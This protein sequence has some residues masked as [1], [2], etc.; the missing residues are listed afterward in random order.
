MFRLAGQVILIFAIARAAFGQSAETIPSFEVADVHVT[1]QSASSPRTGGSIRNGRY[2]IKNLTILDLISL[3]YGADQAKIQGGP[4]WLASDRFDIVAKVP[5]GTNNSTAGLMLRTLLADRFKLAIHNEDKPLP[6]YAL[7]STG[8]RGPQLKEASGVGG[9]C[10]TPPQPNAP[11]EI[12]YIVLSCRNMLMGNIAGVIRAVAPGYLN[13]PVV[14][15]TD[16]KGLWDIELKWT[17]WDLLGA[18][19]SSAISLFDGIEKQ[20]GLKL[21]QRQHPMPVTVVDR[22]NQKPTDNIPDVVQKLPP[23]PPAEFEVADI[24]PS[25]PGA[26]QRGG[27]QPGGRLDL[28]NFSLKNLITLAWSLGDDMVA[29]P[30]WMETERF[31]I[32]AKASGE[33]GA[34]NVDGDTLRLMLRAL[35]IDRFK[36]TMHTENQPRPVYALMTDKREP[37]LKKADPSNRTGCSRVGAPNVGSAPM[38]TMT[39]LNVTLAQ[40]AERLQGLAPAY[41]D[42]P[43]VDLTGLNGAWDITA[44]WTPRAAFELATKPEAAPDGSIT[45]FEAFDKQLSLKLEASMQPMPVVV[46]DKAEQKPTEN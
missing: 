6:V 44:S 13:K 41:L 36:I 35:L 34:G 32:V 1:T 7:I 28:Q 40:L 15:M 38:Q 20:L 2:E 19:G 42:H 16:L 30:K 17:N 9:G 37:R 14:D 33:G 43:V 4:S 39:C 23:P 18:A 12:P 22:V 21:D 10:Q 29:G 31:D 5:A 25:A 46:I 8:K 11:G 24:K 45:V 27:F 3:A 26:Q